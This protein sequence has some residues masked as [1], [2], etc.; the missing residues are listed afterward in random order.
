MSYPKE[1]ILRKTASPRQA[2]EQWAQIAK[3][4]ATA[5]SFSIGAINNG[6]TWHLQNLDASGVELFCQ[7]VEERGYHAALNWAEAY[8]GPAPVS[9]Q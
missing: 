9:Q 8:H 2:V 3:D 1:N 6:V 7:L 5:I 4:E